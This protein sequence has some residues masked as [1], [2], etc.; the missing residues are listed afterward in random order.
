MTLHRH[1]KYTKHTP[2]AGTDRTSEHDNS[3][4]PDK[5]DHGVAL[6][7][8]FFDL[9]AAFMMSLSRPDANDVSC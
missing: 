3:T 8:K 9:H 2:T 1:I 5:G 6:D 7:S 4:S